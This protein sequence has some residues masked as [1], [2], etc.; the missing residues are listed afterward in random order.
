MD[1]TVSRREFAQAL[2]CGVSFSAVVAAP[3]ITV[4]GQEPEKEKPRLPTSTEL[5][6]THIV[7]QFPSEH[8]TE[9]ALEGIAGDIHLDLARGR[10]LSKFALQNSDEPAFVFAAYRSDRPHGGQPKGQP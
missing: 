5:L 10:E 1:E 7:Q 8:Y 2:V 6:L 9:A 4:D 3:D